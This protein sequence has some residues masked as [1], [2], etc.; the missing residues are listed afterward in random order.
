M[1]IAFKYPTMRLYALLIQVIVFILVGTVPSLKLFGQCPQWQPS[2]P[3]TV[4]Q[5]TPTHL[6]ASSAQPSVATYWDFNAGDSKNQATR[7][8]AGTFPILSQGTSGM[9]VE[10]DNGILYGFTVRP[11]SL[12]RIVFPADTTQPPVVS[13]LGNLGIIS[14]GGI[15]VNIVKDDNLYYGLI[16]LNSGDLI[17]LEF[18]S[19]LANI[20]T[21]SPIVLPAG[22]ANSPFYMDLS[23]WVMT[24][25]R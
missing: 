18:G 17:R 13:D 25:W 3:D 10:M 11:N 23:R 19:S 8:I 15:G 14:F 24:L 9:D 6:S 4:C 1:N 12:T 5:N 2:I 22:L 20:P 7:T 21:A 16:N